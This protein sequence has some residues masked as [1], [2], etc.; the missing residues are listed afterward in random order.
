M[1]IEERVKVLENAIKQMLTP[2]KDIPFDLIVKSM[3][4]KRVIA[5][6]KENEKDVKLLS[7]LKN[8]IEKCAN[9]IIT[10]PIPASRRVNE[11]GNDIEPFVKKHC[12][13]ANL[14]VEK[15]KS[16]NGKAKATGY[17][18]ILI[19][20][21]FERPTYIECKTYSAANK[22][23]SLRSFYL[24]PSEDFKV[25]LDA[26]HLVLSFEIAKI[27][28]K[29]YAPTYFKLVDVCNLLCDVKYE[30]NSNNK[31]LYNDN[32]IILEGSLEH[33]AK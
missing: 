23:T 33:Q 10:N 2:I 17:P 12:V 30:F 7:T 4:N 28:G 14:R 25:D 16:K 31:K 3:T 26:R 6:D 8:I 27:D 29:G 32:L 24:S 1:K 20:D 21:E 11:V 15:P 5:F 22:D 13:A 9:D 19:Y 18:D